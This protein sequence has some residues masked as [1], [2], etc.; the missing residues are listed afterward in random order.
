MSC[1]NCSAPVEVPPALAS[2]AARASPGPA[3]RRGGRLRRRWLRRLAPLGGFAAAVAAVALLC[4]MVAARGRPGA[5]EARAA[6]QGDAA[7]TATK[8]FE[9]PSGQRYNNGDQ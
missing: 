4:A 1:P 3:P 8:P 6:E 9:P 7:G 5:A 2:P